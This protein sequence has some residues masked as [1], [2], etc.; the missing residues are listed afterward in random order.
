STAG[1]AAGDYEQNGEQNN[2][3]EDTATEIACISTPILESTTNTMN[4]LT[5]T[6]H[7]YFVLEKTFDEETKEETEHYA[8]PDT[9][10]ADHYDMTEKSQKDTDK[11]YDTADSKMSSAKSELSK[12]NNTYNKV[13][14][15]QTNEYDHINGRPQKS[16]GQTENQYDISKNLIDGKRNTN[17]DKDSD[18]YNHMNIHESKSSGTDNIYGKAE[19]DGDG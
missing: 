14:L 18:T 15:H 16:D 3:T 9:T 7:F 13:T 6:N 17:F 4:D 1:L 5:A 19:T 11:D 2:H 10:D 8:E 12:P